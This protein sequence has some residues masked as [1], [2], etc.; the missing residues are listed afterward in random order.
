MKL[1]FL[2]LNILAIS[3]NANE[4]YYD[5]GN[6]FLN[7]KPGKNFY[8]NIFISHLTHSRNLLLILKL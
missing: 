4:I 7:V 3:L 5:E 8:R 6:T 2:F 1:L